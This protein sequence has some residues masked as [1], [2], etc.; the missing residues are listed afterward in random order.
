[1]P[2]KCGKP[3]FPS[4]KLHSKSFFSFESETRIEAT[5]WLGALQKAVEDAVISLSLSSFFSG[6]PNPY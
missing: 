4:N 1:M 2:A 3:E 5:V 6:N